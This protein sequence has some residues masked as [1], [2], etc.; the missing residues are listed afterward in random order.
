MGAAPAK[1]SKDD[2][3]YI[4]AIHK[5]NKYSKKLYIMDARPKINALANVVREGMSLT[6]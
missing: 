1:R 3:S 4:S 6:L 2:E 5:A